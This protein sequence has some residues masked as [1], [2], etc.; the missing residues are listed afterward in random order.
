V[1]GFTTETRR[2]GD[3]F[4][5]FVIP[6]LFSVFPA[7]AGK[8]KIRKDENERRDHPL[9]RASVVRNLSPL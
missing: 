6:L 1:A 4:S 2:T 9:L 8:T 3:D 7:K 5:F